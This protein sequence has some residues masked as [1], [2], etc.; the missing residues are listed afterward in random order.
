MYLQAPEID[1]VVL[2]AYREGLR[3]G[4][5]CVDP[6]LKPRAFQPRPCSVSLPRRHY[7]AMLDA[8][9]D[10]TAVFLIW[11]PVN[12]PKT[13]GGCVM[14]CITML[15]VLLRLLC[16]PRYLMGLAKAPVLIEDGADITFLSFCRC[17]FVCHWLGNAL[18]GRQIRRQHA[19]VVAR[20]GGGS[21][22]AARSWHSTSELPSCYWDFAVQSEIQ[23]LVHSCAVHHRVGIGLTKD[24]RRLVNDRIK[25]L[26]QERRPNQCCLSPRPRCRVLDSICFC[27]SM[28]W[29]V[30]VTIPS[31]VLL[32]LGWEWRAR[33]RISGDCCCSS[34]PCRRLTAVIPQPLVS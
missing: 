10:Q 26:L 5:Q 6:F 19:S 25:D 11:C 16:L 12:N 2:G 24:E 21:A 33:P 27:H 18:A 30:C 29:Y 31:C 14:A 3:G 28:S 8:C 34:V 7:S 15:L 13:A 20:G 9:T 17:G 4:G 32:A 23:R 22:S 1:A